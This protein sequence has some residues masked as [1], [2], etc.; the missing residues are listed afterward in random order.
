MAVALIRNADLR[1]H[2][3]PA[4]RV[5][6]LSGEGYGR[7]WATIWRF[8]LTFDPE[9]YAAAKGVELDPIA[10]LEHAKSSADARTLSKQTTAWLRTAL[11]AL[12]DD[13]VLGSHPDDCCLPLYDALLDALHLRLTNGKP[14][15]SPERPGPELRIGMT[16]HSLPIAGHQR[17]VFEALPEL[18]RDELYDR[19]AGVMLR[20]KPALTALAA[21]SLEPPIYPH[22]YEGPPLHTITYQLVSL[23]E[24][25][26]ADEIQRTYERFI[27]LVLDSVGLPGGRHLYK[28]DDTAPPGAD[29]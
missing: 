17:F 26:N 14:R 29:G 19:M 18:S 11:W 12:Y 7:H 4:V 10:V 9:S 27:E 8:T 22:E 16:A 20:A 3:V 24:R 5:V 6:D 2:H 23:T 28:H 25:G 21:L 15:P 1:G 13:R